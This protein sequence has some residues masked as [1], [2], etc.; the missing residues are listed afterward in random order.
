MEIPWVAANSQ[1]HHFY[2]AYFPRS[3]ER[4]MQRHTFWLVDAMTLGHEFRLVRR[5]GLLPET[6]LTRAEIWLEQLFWHRRIPLL[7]YSGEA[8]TALFQLM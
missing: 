7:R 2:K 1:T 4:M 8:Y 5:F 3:F 6:F